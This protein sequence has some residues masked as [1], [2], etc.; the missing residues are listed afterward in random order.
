MV[1]I[2]D[3]LF[4]SVVIPAYKEENRIGK[5]LDI[6]KEYFENVR[7]DSYSFEILV[8]IDGSPDKT[9][10]VV[11]EYMKTMSYLRVIDRKENRG[12]GYTIKEGMLEAKG[13]IRLFTDADNSTSIE[14]IEKLLPFFKKGFDVVIGS[15]RAQGAE[16]AVPQP[17]TRTIPGK[18]GNLVIQIFAV[19]GINDTQCGF[20]ALTAEAAQKIF[21]EMVVEGW[22]FDVEMLA[23][24][25]R[26]GLKVKDVGIRWVND[27]LTTVGASAFITTLL[28]VVRI[29]F[30]LWFGKYPKK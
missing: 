5:T 4:L 10:D 8:V 21:P 29:R 30:R 13:V 19:P 28:D 6:M 11:R 2:Q 20:K 16:I 23:L 12:K 27:E 26:F 15:R 17:W 3:E 7:K 18:I 1:N 25:R 22:G 14:Q 9:S 24:A